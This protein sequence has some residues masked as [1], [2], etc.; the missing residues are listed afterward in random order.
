MRSVLQ[1]FRYGLRGIRKQ[2]GFALLAIRIAWFYFHD[3]N[4]IR[5]R[6]PGCAMKG[7]EFLDYQK[8][9]HVFSEVIGGGNEDASAR[10]IT[11]V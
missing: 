9:N 7:A 4:S 2:P 8:Q 1:D 10:L 3:V 11:G 5:E 6:W